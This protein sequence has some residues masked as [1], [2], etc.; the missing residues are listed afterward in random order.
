MKNQK[1]EDLGFESPEQYQFPAIVNL[2]VIRGACPCRCIHCPVGITPVSDRKARFGKSVIPFRLFKRIIREM[3]AFSHSTLR[4]HGVGEPILWKNIVEA[5]RYADSHRVRTWLFTSL[6]TEDLSLLNELATHCTIIEISINSC[7]RADYIK[8]KGIDAFPLVKRNI[9]RLRTSA[10]SGRTEPRVIVS[11]VESDDKY[12]DSAFISYW[13]ASHFTDDAFVR[14]YHDY[15]AILRT[16]KH[17][18]SLEPLSCLVHWNRFNIDC[19]GNVVLC[20]NELFRGKHPDNSLILGNVRDQT[21]QEIW[22]DENLNT[23]RRA[24]LVNDYSMVKF[25]DKLPCPACSSCQPLRQEGRDTSEHQI[26]YLMEK[27]T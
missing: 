18:R 4:I 17:Q 6:V 10:G 16:S 22:H 23:L 24:Q 19:D 25:T 1:M 3:S 7:D 9:E 12:R 2:C 14:T 5:I 15:N 11:R 8:T 21:I 20:F 13:K 26:E 27:G